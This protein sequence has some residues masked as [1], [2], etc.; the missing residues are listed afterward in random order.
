MRSFRVV[1]GETGYAQQFTNLRNDA[2]GGS[3]LHAHQQLGALALPTNP[4][5][6]QT[7]TLTINGNAIVITFVTGSVGTTA[8]NILIQ[9]TAALTAAA[10]LA[11]LNQPQTTTGNAV[12]LSATNQQLV[13]YLAW[14]LVGTTITPS[15]NNNS[16]YAPL[17]SFSAST[18]VTGASWTAQTLKL[19]VEPGVVYVSGTRV[20]FSG[21]STPLVTAP[22]SNPRIDVLTI[23]SSGTLAWT[24]GSENASPS[25]PAYPGNKVPICELYNVVGETALYDF[26]NQQNGQGYIYNDVRAFLQPLMNWT[27]FSS[28]FIPDGDGTRNLGSASFE[29]ENI[30]AKSG[31]FLNG[32]PFGTQLTFSGTALESISAGAPVAIGLLQNTDIGYDT[33]GK[34]GPSGSIT[35]ANNSNRVLVVVAYNNNGTTISGTFAGQSL[36]FTQ[37][38]HVLSATNYSV[39]TA[40]LIAPPTG[41]GSFSLT[42]ATNVFYWSLYNC[43]QTSP[44]DNRATSGATSTSPSISTSLNT[45]GALAVGVLFTTASSANSGSITG[46]VYVEHTSTSSAGPS[47]ALGEAGVANIYAANQVMTL[48]TTGATSEDWLTALVS[49]K[50]ATA[51][52]EGLLNASSASVANGNTRATGFIGFAVSS[53]SASQSLTVALNGVA[54]GLSALILGAE[55]YLN[56]TN[57]TIGIS[58]G[59]TT[60]KVGVA[61]STTQLLIANSW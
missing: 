52:S 40:V 15:S 27:A 58:A 47:Y 35:I 38:S 53:V 25:A 23:D 36:S 51:V 44:Q 1:N 37:D 61:V 4:T 29:W 46:N 55:Y 16:L 33:S 14:S 21:G 48:A 56:D 3:F 41:S 39:A 6:G 11:F 26:D 10:L 43:A 59:T 13:S 31:I 42:N 32:A 2:R 18:T 24:T 12:A 7:L 60:R 54:T 28:D 9:G 30:Y 22:A 45:D 50:P 17:S 34:A 19:Y 57:G 20:I 49:I 5:N 8:G